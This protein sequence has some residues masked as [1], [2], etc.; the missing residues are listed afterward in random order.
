MLIREIFSGWV[1]LPLTDVLADPYILNTLIV[2]ATG[3][4]KVAPLPDTPN[5]RVRFFNIIYLLCICAFLPP[6][7]KWK[8][9]SMNNNSV[10]L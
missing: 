2:L 1:L 6:D 7:G 8:V 4:D 10:Q 3:D 5:Y 9:K